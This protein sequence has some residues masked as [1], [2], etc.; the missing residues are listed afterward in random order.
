MLSEGLILQNN[1]FEASVEAFDRTGS[2]TT[3][4]QY[5]RTSKICEQIVQSG[6]N[7]TSVRVLILIL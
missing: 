7:G 5:V 4:Q 2:H 3:D 1:N 6:T